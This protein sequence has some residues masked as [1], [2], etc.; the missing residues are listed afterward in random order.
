M[1]TSCCLAVSLLGV[2]CFS[3]LNSPRATAQ[4]TKDYTKWMSGSGNWTDTAHWSDG[5]P[6]PY[7]RVEVHG[8][9]TVRGDRAEIRRYH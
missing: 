1:K 9:G 4:S 5:L 3:L 6:D 8:N 7:K 2:I